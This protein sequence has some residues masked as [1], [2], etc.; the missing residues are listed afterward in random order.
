M[1]V[2]TLKIWEIDDGEQSWYSAES[3]EEALEMYLEPLRNP[4]TGEVDKDQL[5]CLV[6]EIEVKELP[7]DAVLPVRNEDDGTT[8]EKTV[9]E[10][11]A[12]GKGMVATTAY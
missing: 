11:A 9:R 3:K 8:V 5:A 2:S 6:E 10:W 7:Q 12:E 4:K 1:E